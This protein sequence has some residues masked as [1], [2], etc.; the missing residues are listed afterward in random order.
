MTDLKQLGFSLKVETAS[1]DQVKQTLQ[2]LKDKQHAKAISNEDVQERILQQHAAL[3]AQALAAQR[4]KKDLKQANKRLKQA[5]QGDAS[6]SGDLGADDMM[7]QF[8]FSAFGTS[9]R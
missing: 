8:G 6:P 3:E 5:A 1:L 4:A 9:K 2:T 7:T